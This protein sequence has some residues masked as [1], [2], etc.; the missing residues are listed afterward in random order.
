MGWGKDPALLLY[1]YTP[2]SSAVG[3]L[4]H[5][6]YCQ[7]FVPMILKM[8]VKRKFVLWQPRYYNLLTQKKDRKIHAF[9]VLFFLKMCC[10]CQSLGDILLGN[11]TLPNSIILAEDLIKW[12]RGFEIFLIDRYA[13]HTGNKIIAGQY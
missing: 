2:S 5:M 3:H 6:R 11:F 10:Y 9:E 1:T 12:K 13:G 7:R 8:W 4:L